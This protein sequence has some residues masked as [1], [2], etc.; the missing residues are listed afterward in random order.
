MTLLALLVVAS[1]LLTASPAA[2][3]SV[4]SLTAPTLSS[5]AAGVPHVRYTFSFTASSLLVS[6]G[7]ITITA[8]T[9]TTL[10][11]SAQVHDDTTNTSFSRSGTRVNNNTTLT[12]TLCCGEVINPADHVTVTL[13]D[14]TNATSPPSPT[15]VVSTSTDQDP[16]TSPPYT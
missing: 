7:T 5:T 8:P 10:P 13:E 16:A 2:A 9:G 1:G 14:V 12:I 3:T 6:G 4:Q 11:P 15:L